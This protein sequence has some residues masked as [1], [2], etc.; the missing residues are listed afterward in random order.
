MY[1]G[2]FFSFKLY[3]FNKSLYLITVWAAIISDT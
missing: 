1:I 2:D 3:N